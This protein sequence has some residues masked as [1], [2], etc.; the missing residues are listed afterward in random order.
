M[1]KDEQFETLVKLIKGTEAKFTVA[2][3]KT[4][5]K[6]DGA[7]KQMEKRFT[8]ALKQTEEKLTIGYRKEMNDLNIG[9]VREMN[10]IRAEI[11]INADINGREH[12][13]MID[14]IE[15]RYSDLERGIQD[16]E[17]SID[18]LYALSKMNEMKH[19]EYERIFARNNLS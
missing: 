18:T 13:T 17:Q 9:L 10:R 2:L 15:R 11:R 16:N 19:K 14:T 8:E 6:F 7:L 4:E 5:E 12:Q 3:N 1:M